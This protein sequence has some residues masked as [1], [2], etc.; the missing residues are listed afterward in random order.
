VSEYVAAT[1]GE[2][3]PP[4]DDDATTRSALSDATYRERYPKAILPGLI[5]AVVHHRISL[6]DL[7]HRIGIKRARVYR[8]GNGAQAAEPWEIAKIMEALNTTYETL[9]TEPKEPVSLPITRRRKTETI[10]EPP[11]LPPIERDEEQASLTLVLPNGKQTTIMTS[12]T[13]TTAITLR[14]ARALA[15]MFDLK[16][17]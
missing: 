6:A 1:S 10:S 13:I 17:E 14:M 12:E 8:L 7:A 2:D 4:H 15:V 5:A 9:I 3:L 11:G 16:D